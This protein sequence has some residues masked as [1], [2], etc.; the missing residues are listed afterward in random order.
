VPSCSAAG[1]SV[2]VVYGALGPTVR[3][4]EARRFREGEAEVLVATDAIGMGLNIGP[5]RR[6]IFS[7]LRKYDGQQERPLSVQEIKQIGGRAGR[8]GGEH[9]E[10]IVA[11]LAGGGDPATIA[12]ALTAGATPPL[13]LRPPVAPDA[14]IVAAVAAEIGTDSLF[15]VLSRIERSVLR[16]DDPNY[17]L[18]D[19][20]T[21][22]AIAGAVD[23]VRELSLLDRWTY[24]MCPWTSATKA[25]P[26]WRTGPSST[27]WGGRWPRRVLAGCP[28]PTGPARRPCS[29]P[30]GCTGAWLLGAGWLC[31]FPLFT[32]T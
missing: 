4:A 25:F 31:A 12:S 21:Q 14:D 9:A 23:G 2:A 11:V 8:F 20:S 28:R 32:A 30:S 18:G 6:V 27:R 15:G 29:L 19:L 16:R 26:A 22:I 1:G 24:A 7:A 17:R 5:L 13:D 10:G 3:R